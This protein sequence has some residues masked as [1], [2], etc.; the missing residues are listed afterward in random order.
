MP[1][2]NKTRCVCNFLSSN[3]MNSRALCIEYGTLRLYQTPIHI[4][5]RTIY[6]RDHSYRARVS[7]VSVGRLEVHCR[8]IIQTTHGF[9]LLWLGIIYPMQDLRYS[10]QRKTQ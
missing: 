5:N 8:K 6:N 4:S 9:S 2:L 3:P 10:A 7:F 1:Y